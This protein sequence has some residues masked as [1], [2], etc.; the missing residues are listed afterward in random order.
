[1]LS[2]VISSVFLAITFSIVG[3]ISLVNG[4]WK[5]PTEIKTKQF[6]TFENDILKIDYPVN[7]NI[8]EEKD[9]II[10]HPNKHSSDHLKITAISFP[11]S[12]ITLKSIVDSTL[13]Q[14]AKNLT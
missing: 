7:W 3:N 1:M 13:D 11:S 4:E 10:F 14:F 8:T 12:F 9:S 5:I 6:T 2:I